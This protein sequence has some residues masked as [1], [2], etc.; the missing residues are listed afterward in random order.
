MTHCVEAAPEFVIHTDG[1]CHP[2][3]GPGGWAAVLQYVDSKGELLSRRISGNCK[4]T[5]NNRMEIT[6]VLS[7]LQRLKYPSHVIVHCDSRYVVSAIGNWENG[8]PAADRENC[9]WIV[10]WQKKRWKRRLRRRG[11]PKTSVLK[12]VDLWRAVYKEV[13]RHASVDMRWVRGHAGNEMNELCDAIAVQQR[14]SVST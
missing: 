8:V 1:S 13:R 5:T 11:K 6:A 10:K 9:G 7:A 4:Q 2:N 3:P 12:N 14:R